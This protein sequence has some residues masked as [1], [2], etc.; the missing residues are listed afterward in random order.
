MIGVA[1]TLFGCAGPERLT[2][3]DGEA[4]PEQVE[5]AD[6]P[7]DT[8]QQILSGEPLELEDCIALTLERNYGLVQAAYAEGVAEANQRAALAPLFP[9]LRGN[10]DFQHLQPD[11]EV[12]VG[13]LGQEVPLVGNPKTDFSVTAAWRVWDFGERWF[14]YRASA[15]EVQG[16]YL[17]RLRLAQQ[18]RYQAAAAWFQI[19]VARSQ[20]EVIRA[21]LPALEKALENQRALREQGRGVEADVLLVSLA[22]ETRRRELQRAR[23]TVKQSVWQLNRL[24]GMPIGTPTQPADPDLELTGTDKPPLPT[25]EVCLQT[26]R[27]SHPE[28]ERVGAQQRSLEQQRNAIRATYWPTVDV[29]GTYTHTTD[30]V[31]ANEDTVAFTAA[32]VWPIFDGGLRESELRAN[33]ARQKATTSEM[34]EVLAQIDLEVREARLQLDQVWADWLLAQQA[35]KQAESELA[36][37]RQRVEAGL[38]TQ[39]DA[40]EAEGRLTARKI[41]QARLVFAWFA[42]MARLELAVG[43]PLP[44]P[45]PQQ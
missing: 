37:E 26:A 32:L 43:G 21:S 13:F 2:R 17:Q 6:R 14:R 36:R 16:A 15:E 1:T 45:E 29:A 12:D 44:N 9:T 31:A 33:T 25:V 39:R 28:I 4:F 38:S 40:L 23:D 30:E 5:D 3:L 24:M 10:I 35:V 22:L 11:P 18:V 41:E 27:R 20:V 7:R 8:A 34:L 19:H 42:S